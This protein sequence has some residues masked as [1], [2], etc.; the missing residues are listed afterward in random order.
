MNLN[1]LIKNIIAV[2]KSFYGKAMM[3]VG[4]KSVR[5]LCVGA[6]CI[7][8]FILASSFAINQIQANDKDLKKKFEE[9]EKWHK[10]EMKKLYEPYDSPEESTPAPAPRPD[11]FRLREKCKKEIMKAPKHEL[12]IKLDIS[13]PCVD[14]VIKDW[15]CTKDE[16][17]IDADKYVKAAEDA[18]LNVVKQRLGFGNL[19]KEE[20]KK[21]Y[22]KYLEKDGKEQV[23]RLIKRVQKVGVGKIFDPQPGEKQT[24]KRKVCYTFEEIQQLIDYVIDKTMDPYK[25][26]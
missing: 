3:C 4:A 9:I 12:K 17:K 10:K 6:L 13:D 15:F 18:A 19:G 21:L 26:D 14:V 22:H 25:Q 1:G 2:R 20:A 5:A 8:A 24:Y 23:K 16:K 11:Y 7:S